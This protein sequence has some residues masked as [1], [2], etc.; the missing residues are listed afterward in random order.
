MYRVLLEADPEFQEVLRIFSK[1]PTLDEM[2]VYSEE[3]KGI[4]KASV[5]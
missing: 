1:M 5:E 4:K 3:Q 2:F